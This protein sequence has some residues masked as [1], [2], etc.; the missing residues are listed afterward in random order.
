MLFFVYYYYIMLVVGLYNH[1]VLKPV[2]DRPTLGI[3]TT[4]ERQHDSLR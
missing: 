4:P 1:H 2:L 3:C